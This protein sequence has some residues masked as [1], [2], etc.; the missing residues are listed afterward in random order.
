MDKSRKTR[1]ER[2]MKKLMIVLII[3]LPLTVGLGIWLIAKLS[4]SGP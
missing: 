4:R 2:Q 1:W 3:V